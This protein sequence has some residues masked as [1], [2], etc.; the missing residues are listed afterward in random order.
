MGLESGGPH[1]EPT[2]RHLYDTY[3]APLRELAL[4]GNRPEM[5]RML[6]EEQVENMDLDAMRNTLWS[7]EFR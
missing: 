2:V 6:V 4:Y 5:F 3:R 1:D 7:T